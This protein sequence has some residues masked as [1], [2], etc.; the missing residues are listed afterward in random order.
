MKFQFVVWGYN[1]KAVSAFYSYAE[2]KKFF[3][4]VDAYTLL[5][6]IRNTVTV[7]LCFCPLCGQRALSI[8]FLV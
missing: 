3:C 7:R 1:K 5:S 8:L 6:G 2:F 4:L